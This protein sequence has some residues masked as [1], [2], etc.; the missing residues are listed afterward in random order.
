MNK[1]NLQLFLQR[2]LTVLCKPKLQR[3]SLGDAMN[4]LK[5]HSNLMQRLTRQEFYLLQDNHLQK[6]QVLPYKLDDYK[7]CRFRADELK[8]MQKFLNT[9]NYLVL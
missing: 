1:E 5:D 2:E 7:S 3:I 6:A 4:Y 9:A 8:V